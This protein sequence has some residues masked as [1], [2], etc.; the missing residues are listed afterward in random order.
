MGAFEDL[1]NFAGVGADVFGTVQ[2]AKS[3]KKANQAMERIAK[4]NRDFQERMSNTAHQREV[5]DLRAAGLNPILSATGGPG[6]STPAGATAAQMNEGESYQ[7]LG[8]KLAEK[9][10]VALESKANSA[11]VATQKS[12]QKLNKQLENR[13]SA[14]SRVTAAQ[15]PHAL[16]E[17]NLYS[18]TAGQWL[19]TAD[20]AA[21]VAAKWAD[22]LNFKRFM[23]RQFDRL[24]EGD[25]EPVGFNPKDALK[26]KFND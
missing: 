20:K 26:L 15:L 6:A 4:E 16:A 1:V 5:A 19:V 23:A 2:S 17:A 21:D 11:M 9:V 25:K 8:S 24:E 13:A 3:A 10:R 7:N 18:S 22:V 14:E 12:Q